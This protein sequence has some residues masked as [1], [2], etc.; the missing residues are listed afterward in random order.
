M[1]NY[2]S[3]SPKG[4]LYGIVHMS[5]AKCE[6]IDIDAPAHSFQGGLGILLEERVFKYAADVRC[7]QTPNIQRSF[8]ITL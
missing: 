1:R 6:S 2:L 4:A 7:V 3:L 8:V 5:A